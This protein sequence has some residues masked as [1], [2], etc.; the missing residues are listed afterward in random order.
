MPDTFNSVCK[1]TDI[2][3]TCPIT[4][5]QKHVRVYGFFTNDEFHGKVLT[6][7]RD[8]KHPECKA[9]HAHACQRYAELLRTGPNFQ[10][11]L[12]TL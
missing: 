8:Q 12:Q 4:G 5:E 3:V 9:C 6:D 7:K 10:A 11:T 2:S 1:Y